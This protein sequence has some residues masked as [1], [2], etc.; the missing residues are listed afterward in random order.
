MARNKDRSA[1]SDHKTAVYL[2]AL[3]GTILVML[4]V[5]FAIVNKLRLPTAQFPMREISRCERRVNE[6]RIV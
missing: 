1:C 5:R 4:M 2:A 3:Y 6:T